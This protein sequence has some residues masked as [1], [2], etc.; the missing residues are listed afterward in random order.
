M[1]DF[2]IR[3]KND[4]PAILSYGFRP[5][6][7]SGALWAVVVVMLWLP[8]YFGELTLSNAF[9]PM[10]WHAHEALFGYGAAVVAGFLL[11][12][13]PNWTGRF[14]LRGK[15]L[16]FLF[17]VWLAGRLAV[18]LSGHIGWLAAALV[19]CAFLFTFA[20]FIGREIVAGKNWRNL[21]VLIVVVFLAAANV[22]FHVEAHFAG[23]AA[24]SR[25]F[26]I[27]VF[28]ALIMLVGGRIVPSFTHTFLLQRR[29]AG[30]LPQKFG[31]FDALCM[32]ASVA[33]LAGW[34]AAPDNKGVGL[35]L[36]VAGLLNAARLAR[37]AGERTS[38]EALVLILHLA[39]A[40]IP[41]GFLLSGLAAW[42][43]AI[44]PSAGLHAWAVGAI[45]GMTIA[46]MTR[47]SLGHTGQAL[48]AGPG[49]KLLYASIV[50]AALARIA[51]AL[52]PQ[53]SFILLHV[54]AFAW[55]AAFLGFAVAYGPAL[56]RARL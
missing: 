11:T 36:I 3:R 48:R 14:P 40:F 46:V 34:V 15:G 30:R 5:F 25:R 10:D 6:F 45:G 13:V 19:D 33:A 49:T 27:A 1:S 50:L 43:P 29:V 41:I 53:W 51:A 2:G 52:A 4:G 22:A 23:D 44:S 47:A 24:F 37:W 8:Q 39:F 42:V 17:L 12:A 55:L 16:L 7:L 56:F 26:A 32:A 31:R 28:V 21:R 18:A 20:F 9:Q 38:G 54:A 35:A